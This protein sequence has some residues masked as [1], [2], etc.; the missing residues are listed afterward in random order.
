MFLYTC[1]QLDLYI[2]MYKI[3]QYT[4]GFTGVSECLTFG[5]LFYIPVVTGFVLLFKQCINKQ[6]NFWNLNVIVFNILV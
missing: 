2:I 5:I 1:L 3:V 6:G 4:R